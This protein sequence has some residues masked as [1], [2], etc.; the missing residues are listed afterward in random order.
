M[1]TLSHLHTNSDLQN[2][3]RIIDQ[4]HIQTLTLILLLTTTTTTTTTVIFEKCDEVQ[5]TL[6]QQ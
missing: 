5:V 3:H 4:N 6:K 1:I 2:K